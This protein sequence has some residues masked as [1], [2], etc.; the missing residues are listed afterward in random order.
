VIGDGDAMGIAAEV[1]IDLL[2]PA[3]RFFAV[4]DP[5]LPPEFLEE[6]IRG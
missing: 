6:T 2:G 3:E 4:D 1:G 5:F